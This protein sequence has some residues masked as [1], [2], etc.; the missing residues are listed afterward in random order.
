MAINK[1]TETATIDACLVVLTKED[2]SKSAIG[3]TSNTEVATEIQTEETDDNKLIIKNKL[4]AQKIGKKTVTGVKVT[5]TDNLTILEL[6]QAVQGGTITRDESGKIT[7]Y[8]PPLIDSDVKQEKYTLDI[9]S[10][11]MDTSGD[12]LQYEKVTY[13]HCTGDPVG[14]NAKDDEWRTTEYVLKSLP[15]GDEAPYEVTYVDELP[16]VTEPTNA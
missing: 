5:L 7:K 14:Y 3:I 11:C 9:Y 4:K 10:A 15:K 1:P 6:A 8:T 2:E 16:T 13:K 12:V